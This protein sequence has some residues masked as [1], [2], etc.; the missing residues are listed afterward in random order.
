MKTILFTFA[1]D[2]Y[3]ARE[4][5]SSARG[6]L[7][8]LGYEALSPIDLKP[9][10][11]WAQSTTEM[12][13]R[14]S[15]VIAFLTERSSNVLFETGY[16]FGLGKNVVLV[17]DMS[18]LPF[19]LRTVAAI[20]AR[21]SPTEIAFE[22]VR[23]INRLESSGWQPEVALPSNLRD[24]LN[25]RQTRPELFELINERLFEQAIADEFKAQ[26]FQVRPVEEYDNEYGYDFRA[27][28]PTAG[29]MLV[30]IKKRN[31]NSKVSISSVQQLLGVAH[32]YQDHAALL[33]CT[34]DFTDSAREFAARQSPRIRLWTI[35]ELT[36]FSER[37]TGQ[38]NL[39]AVLG[40]KAVPET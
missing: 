9:G 36:T 3:K 25:L 33:V 23:Q 39:E 20:D 40:I 19:D 28:N 7:A 34:S 6:K 12:L 4:V 14:S 11:E 15:V 35:N 2:D 30:E 13:K 27:W 21:S 24:I 5:L 16:A 38:G 26:G 18:T 22:I 10:D 37:R 29:S 1:Y 31:L 17:S 8:N 32:A